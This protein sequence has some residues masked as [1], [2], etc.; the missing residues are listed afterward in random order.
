MD[1]VRSEGTASI[2]AGMMPKIMAPGSYDDD[3]LV[4]FVREIM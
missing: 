2:V 1:T 4:D 3:E